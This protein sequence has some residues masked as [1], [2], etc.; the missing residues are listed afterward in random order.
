MSYVQIREYSKENFKSEISLTSS[1]SVVKCEFK[2]KFYIL[3]RV[4]LADKFWHNEEEKFDYI[5][6]KK[7]ELKIMKKKSHQ[8][9]VKIYGYFHDDYNHELRFSMEVF[10]KNLRDLINIQGVFRFEKFLPLL[11]GLVEGKIYIFSS[12]LNKYY[13]F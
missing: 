6:R 4:F 12:I 7:D 13:F 5:E 8:N 3:K 9:I 1:E 10:E 2:G 11:K